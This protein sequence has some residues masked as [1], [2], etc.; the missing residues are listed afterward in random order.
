MLG[1]TKA[2]TTAAL[3]AARLKITF[4]IF[5]APDFMDLAFLSGSQAMARRSV[6][7]LQSKTP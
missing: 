6:L 3:N 1:V 7:A 2:A 5:I 4:S